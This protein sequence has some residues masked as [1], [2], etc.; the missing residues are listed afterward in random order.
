MVRDNTPLNGLH[1]RLM[2]L[3]EY[4]PLMGLLEYTPRDGVVG[5][6]LP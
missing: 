6:H 2:G 5:I 3:L 1:A 4:T